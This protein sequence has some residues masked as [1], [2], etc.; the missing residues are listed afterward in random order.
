MG[1]TDGQT[2][3]IGGADGEHG[4]NLRCRA[5]RISQVV[6]ADLFT[7]R[8]HDPLPADHG[9]ES[10]RHGNRDFHPDGNEARRQVNVF[11]S[12]AA[13]EPENCA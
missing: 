9:S 1:R 10:E 12:T 3:V 7:D 6:L 5:L 8:D 4:G 11:A 2:H 13:S